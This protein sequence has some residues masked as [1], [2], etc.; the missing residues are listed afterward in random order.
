MNKIDNVDNYTEFI[1]LS[2]KL[3]KLPVKA[4]QRLLTENKGKAL[5]AQ[6]RAMNIDGR[7][8]DPDTGK[9]EESWKCIS[10]RFANGCE[11]GNDHLELE[12]NLLSTFLNALQSRTEAIH[13]KLMFLESKGYNRKVD[14]DAF[15]FTCSIE[16]S[17]YAKIVISCE[18]ALKY[19][20]NFYRRLYK[21]WEWGLDD[22][23]ITE[24]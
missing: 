10:Q 6:L 8:Q 11:F 19:M 24:L 4:P 1:E 22:E 21:T 15:H 20:L 2:W 14:I 9:H 3:S 7:T 18:P 16:K 23:V 17:M 5:L 13:N 12:N